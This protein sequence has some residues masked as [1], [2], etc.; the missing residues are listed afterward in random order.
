M[1]LGAD[2][3]SYYNLATLLLF[4]QDSANGMDI[5]LKTKIK[6]YQFGDDF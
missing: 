6:R 3:N 5:P 4:I 2:T 1:F